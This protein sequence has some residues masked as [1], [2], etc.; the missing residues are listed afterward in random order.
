LLSFGREPRTRPEAFILY[1]VRPVAFKIVRPCRNLPVQ[2]VPF[3][4]AYGEGGTVEFKRR[5]GA[6]Y[7][8]WQRRFENAQ[9]LE[10]KN[11]NHY[12]TI[13]SIMKEGSSPSESVLNRLAPKR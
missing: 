1:R 13:E 5:S 9:L 3:L 12:E 7:T 6:S 2:G 10:L 8:A 4:V 11:L